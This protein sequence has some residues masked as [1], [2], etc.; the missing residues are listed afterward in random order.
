MLKNDYTNF[1]DRNSFSLEIIMCDYDN[2][3]SACEPNDKI[4]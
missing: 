3:K 4:K 2:N 1:T